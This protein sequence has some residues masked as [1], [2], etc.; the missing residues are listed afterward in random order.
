MHS[1]FAATVLFF[2][3]TICSNVVKFVEQEHKQQ[4]EP[5]YKIQIYI[6]ID[7]FF[8][9]A[10]GLDSRCASGM[11]SCR[12]Q[13]QQQQQSH[14]S[15]RFLLPFGAQELRYEAW[16]KKNKHVN[17]H[18]LEWSWGILLQGVLQP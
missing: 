17:K 12:R 15:E 7:F 11:G 6:Q 16:E 1:T 10:S 8:H 5:V 3:T 4:N 14:N 9:K 13:Q 2:M 18:E